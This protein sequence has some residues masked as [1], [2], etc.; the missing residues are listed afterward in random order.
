MQKAG[1]LSLRRHVSRDPEEAR[2]SHLDIWEKNTAGRTQ[3]S[4]KDPKGELDGK[5]SRMVRR[6][7]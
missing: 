5:V 1:K 4:T 6:P 3:P 2:T 7:T